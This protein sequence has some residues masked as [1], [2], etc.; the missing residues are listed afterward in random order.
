MEALQRSEANALKPPPVI[1][2]EQWEEE[3][4]VLLFC[5]ITQT[6]PSPFEC[7]GRHWTIFFVINYKL[8]EVADIDFTFCQKTKVKQIWLC[9]MFLF[10]Q[11]NVQLTKYSQQ[12]IPVNI[13]NILAVRMVYSMLIFWLFLFSLVSYRAEG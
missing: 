10:C 11:Y 12:E 4:R 5:K 7:T 6:S 1:T 9:H 3:G 13:L 2:R 8:I